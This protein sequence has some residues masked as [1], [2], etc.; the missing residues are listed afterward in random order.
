MPVQTRSMTRNLHLEQKEN[1]ESDYESDWVDETNENVTKIIHSKTDETI[2]KICYL[3]EKINYL[4]KKNE[5][6]T[7]D[8]DKLEEKIRMTV[9]TL[10]NQIL[11][12]QVK[13]N[14]I[15]KLKEENKKFRER[16]LNIRSKALKR[17][18]QVMIL[19]VLILISI[20]E[21]LYNGVLYK[22]TTKI[23]IPA[24]KA[25]VTTTNYEI[26]IIRNI[27]LTILIIYYLNQ[28]RPFF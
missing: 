21:N 9:L 5:T 15:S 24:S 12:N 2:D 20:V 10:N 7:N 23:I 28:Q 18:R 14:E 27:F 8:R 3:L 16:I 6:I 4:E 19:A 17:K 11:E 25:L 22:I 13:N 26:I 1:E